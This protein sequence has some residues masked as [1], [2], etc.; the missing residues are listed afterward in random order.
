MDKLVGI[1][2]QHIDE[3]ELNVR[4]LYEEMGMS[5]AQFFRKVKSISDLSPNRLI[6]RIK[7]N[8]AAEMLRSGN[9]NISEAA[10][11]T[12]YADPSYFTKVFKSIY[13]MSPTEYHGKYKK[14]Q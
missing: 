12:V 10:Y 6:V 1:I 8:M 9:M 13:G 7:M 5:R 3:P 2:K 11:N 4:F 14:P